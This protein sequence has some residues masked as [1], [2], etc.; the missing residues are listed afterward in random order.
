MLVFGTRMHIITF[1]IIV[2]EMLFFFYQIVHFLSRPSDKKRLYYVIL[3]Y[4]LIQYNLISGLFPNPDYSLPVLFQNIILFVAGIIMA[5][6]FPYYFYKAFNLSK[7]KFYAYWGSVCFLLIPFI[8][9]F[10]IPYCITQDFESSKK[11]LL[12]V[13]FCYAA[14]FI[15][16]LNK[17]IKEQS[18]G[19]EV[20]AF[21]NEIINVYIGAF[22][23]ITLPV[24]AYFE[25]QTN[26]FFE[27]IFHFNDC[28]QVIEMITTNAGLVMMT[29]LFVGQSIRQSR[30][31]YEKLLH[32]ENQLQELNFQLQ[33]SNDDLQLK[34]IERTRELEIANEQRT[35]TF[36]NLAHD[37]KTPLTLINNYLEDFAN[38]YP[39]TESLKVVQLNIEKLTRN[40]VNFF[41][42][43]RI[44]K[45]V[46]IYN[47]DQIA[48]FSKILN[49][50]VVLF[51]KYSLKKAIEVIPS[52]E[53]DIF[54]KADAEALNRII[55]NVIENAIKYTN[56]G[57]QVY[58][59]LKSINRRVY[60]SVKDT[61]IGIIPDLHEKIFDPYYQINSKKANS[62]G[63]GLGL[64]I[65]KK[66]LNGLDGSIQ[67]NSDPNVQRGTEIIIQFSRYYVE[68][69]ELIAEFRNSVKIHE[70]VNQL[71]AKDEIRNSDFPTL[72]VVEDNVQ[73][74]NFLS[75]E[76]KDNYSIYIALSGNE[77]IEKLKTIKHLD[78]IVSD[79]MMDN[80][81]GFELYKY[82]S[83]QKRF[84]HIPFVF[85]TA[86]TEDKLQG[87]SM[88]AIDYI[89]K[90]FLIKELIHKIESVLNNLS[91]QRRAI[92]D[93]IHQSIVSKIEPEQH[94]Q[95]TQDRFEENCI[96]YNLT[97]Q[98]KKIVH[99]IA[100]GQSQK[101]IADTLC[102]SDKT[103]KTH[104]RNLFDKVLV[105]S[106]VEL[107]GKLEITL[108]NDE[109]K[110]T[111]I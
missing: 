69:G 26:A 85:L 1:L 68:K 99:L 16:S 72:L 8:I 13:A 14:S 84:R 88:G 96:K 41:D 32:S 37:I 94:T 77:A 107:L 29:I 101:E 62:Q 21:R 97:P 12:I 61:G 39:P 40:V 75:E 6:Y 105:T 59:T 27:P 10:L 34:V 86:K 15:Y 11:L 98:E 109:D 19:Q 57:G 91:E 108:F 83:E 64:S 36:I 65:T 92:I 44:K 30:E 50:D 25:V 22:F 78:L 45:G 56:E 71:I 73:L 46:T 81:N 52:I 9:F 23:W 58:V 111:R 100:K 54:I 3:L 90:P 93:T 28:S 87:L 35:N 79:V 95:S 4:L 42:S 66:I 18:K 74:L 43:E 24:I 53:D 82:V 80:G 70:E 17:A 106:K 48:E 63:M 38:E 7:L 51:Q 103:V 31:E 55:N 5:M 102:I 104:M 67:I 2:V 110:Y 33:K 47:H 49:D 20:L 60:F 89:L 76:L